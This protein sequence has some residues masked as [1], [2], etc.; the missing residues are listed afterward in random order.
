MNWPDDAAPDRP[1][2][3]AGA[4]CGT[5][6]PLD[7]RSATAPAAQ[8]MAW[9]LAEVDR[10]HASAVMARGRLPVRTI[11]SSIHR[12][13]WLHAALIRRGANH[14]RVAAEDGVFY[15]FGGFVEQN[16]IATRD[17]CA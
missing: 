11:S 15:A 14:I 5:S 4:A 9:T 1:D 7:E 6:R 10:M 16:R 12:G 17:C 2:T 13:A 3:I 8:E